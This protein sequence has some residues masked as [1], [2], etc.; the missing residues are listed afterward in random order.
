MTIEQMRKKTTKELQVHAKNLQVE[1]A[2]IKREKLQ[3]DE[4]NVRKV[5]NLKREIARALTLAKEQGAET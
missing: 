5:K 4:K 1:I 3:S 2:T